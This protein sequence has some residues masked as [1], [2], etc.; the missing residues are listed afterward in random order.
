MGTGQERMADFSDQLDHLHLQVGRV[1]PPLPS[2]ASHDLYESH[3]KK[4][5]IG[6]NAAGCGNKNGI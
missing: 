2:T 1:P 4:T 3:R 5:M 6:G